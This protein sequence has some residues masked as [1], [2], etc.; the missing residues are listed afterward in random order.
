MELVLEGLRDYILGAYNTLVDELS[1][2]EVPLVAIEDRHCII[3]EIDLDKQTAKHV[4]CIM[5]QQEEY[6]ELSLGENQALLT[7]EVFIFVG[8]ES[9]RLLYQQAQRYGAI[10]KRAIYNDPTLDGV[11][12]HTTVTQMDIFQGVEGSPDR[13]AVMLTMELTYAFEV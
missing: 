1:T 13:Q 10:L 2:P 4:V 6:E 7:V 3:G 5:P 11:V 9:P 12:E 8:K